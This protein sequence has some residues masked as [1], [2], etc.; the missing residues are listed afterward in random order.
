MKAQFAV[1]GK[2]WTG[3]QGGTMTETV[4]PAVAYV[5]GDT[6]IKGQTY[7][8]MME[9]SFAGSVRRPTYIGAIREDETGKVFAVEA[10]SATEE[11]AM[12]FGLEVGDTWTVNGGR[13]VHKVMAVGSMSTGSGERR[14]Q[15][16]A[17]YDA[18]DP[19]ENGPLAIL[20]EDIGYNC[21]LGQWHGWNRLG[22]WTQLQACYEQDA[23]IFR[24]E[25]ANWPDTF[26][27]VDSLSPAL[28]PQDNGRKTAYD[29]QGRRLELA[30][31]R[32][33]YIRDGRKTV[34]R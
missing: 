28:S 12:D 4:W 32:G 3:E 7:K 25:E 10:E 34:R 20:T 31:G 19:S 30:P 21:L 29:M 14:I 33:I 9:L 26:G 24:A 27:L 17:E 11:L 13:T 1:N 2:T 8:K 23:C 6:I 22:T 5:E 15:V 18:D 16:V